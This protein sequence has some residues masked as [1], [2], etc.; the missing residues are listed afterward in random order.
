MAFFNVEFG[1]VT[2]GEE[3]VAKSLGFDDYGEAREA[4]LDLSTFGFPLVE[5]ERKGPRDAKTWFARLVAAG[6]V[7]EACSYEPGSIPAPPRM[8]DDPEADTYRIEV[9]FMRR[10]ASGTYE[11][12]AN[13]GVLAEIHAMPDDT[14][15][16]L[17]GLDGRAGALGR[18]ADIDV[19]SIRKDGS[20]A[21]VDRRS[22][23]YTGVP[24]AEAAAAGMNAAA[25]REVARV[26]KCCV[27]DVV[28][29]PLAAVVELDGEFAGIVRYS[30]RTDI[31]F[32]RVNSEILSSMKAMAAGLAW[33]AA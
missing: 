32:G 10:L 17:C 12:P 19:V 30:E 7:L 33:P 16:K 5:T 27:D 29:Y 31:K 18:R 2:D 21:V 14:V 4:Y 1:G 25:G 28:G 3:V 15:M 6:D 9:C 22:F 11:C 13:P 20:R 24:R 23:D 26:R 8:P